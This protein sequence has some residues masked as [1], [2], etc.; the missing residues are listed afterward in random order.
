MNQ[1]NFLV[2][3][4]KYDWKRFL[5]WFA[6]AW[7]Q[8]LDWFT[9]VRIGSEWILI[10]K[11]RQGIPRTISSKFIL[12]LLCGIYMNTLEWEFVRYSG[13]SFR[14]IHSE[15]IWTIPNRIR[16]RIDWN[17]KIGLDQ[18]ESGLSSRVRIDSNWLR[19]INFQ[20]IFNKLDWKISSNCFKVIGLV[21]D[22]GLIRNS[23]DWSQTCEDREKWNFWNYFHPDFGIIRCLLAQN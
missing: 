8:I 11:F 14:G 15:P 5:D 23:S 16:V 10:Q 3:F 1:I 20:V 2:I 18:P 12:G 7:T 21:T 4:S 13:E 6:L 17:W 22:F 9:I 19:R